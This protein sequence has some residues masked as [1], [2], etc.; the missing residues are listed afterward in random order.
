[1]YKFFL[2]KT[3]YKDNIF[4][5]DKKIDIEEY[6]SYAKRWDKGE[7]LEDMVDVKNHNWKIFREVST[8]S[9]SL[10]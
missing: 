5:G 7:Q 2:E 10:I 6:I 4:H 1:M 3:M 8:L 9:K